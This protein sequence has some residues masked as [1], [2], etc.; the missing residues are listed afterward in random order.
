M[1]AICDALEEASDSFGG[2]VA[3]VAT[4][5]SKVT[6]VNESGIFYSVGYSIDNTERVSFDDIEEM[7]VPLITEKDVRK[8]ALGSFFDGS[9]DELKEAVGGM[10]LDLFAKDKTPK[11][12][13]EKVT[14]QM[15]HLFD[16]GSAWRSYVED[17][18]E[19]LTRIAF[20]TSLGSPRID[21][22]PCFEEILDGSMEGDLEG[23]REDVSIALS[24]LEGRVVRLYESTVDCINEYKEVASGESD[25]EAAQLLGRFDDF[26]SDYLEHLGKV[27]GFVSESISKNRSGCVMCGALVHDEIAKRVVDLELGGRL[28]RKVSTDFTR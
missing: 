4:F 15:V 12:P 6:V 17:N 9:G 10:M 25:Q 7:N 13:L 22:K 2:S 21:T 3:V 26:C 11:T 5:P 19:V 1:T 14:E 20:D 8:K 27:G 23:F 18:R 16:E 28:I 24:K